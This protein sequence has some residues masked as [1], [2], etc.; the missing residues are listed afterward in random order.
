M[1]GWRGHTVYH[2]FYWYV[3]KQFPILITSW[4]SCLLCLCQYVG[5]FY[6]LTDLGLFF[7]IRFVGNGLCICDGYWWSHSFQ[8]ILQS[9]R[10][11]LT[12]ITH[13]ILWSDTNGAYHEQIYC[14]YFR[15][16]PCCALHFKI[17]VEYHSTDCIQS[18][19]CYLQYALFQCSHTSFR[20]F[21]LF[22]P[23]IHSNSLFKKQMHAVTS[24]RNFSTQR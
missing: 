8:E 23:G 21:L 10:P 5:Q 2:L 4:L 3:I 1:G 9:S 15:T 7:L 17:H 20:N 22:C 24:L 18:R 19:C 16:W 11:Q 12:A 6:M 13:V 14:R